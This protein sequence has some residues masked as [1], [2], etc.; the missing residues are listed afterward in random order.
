VSHCDTIFHAYKVEKASQGHTSVNTEHV[1]RGLQRCVAV[2][3]LGSYLNPGCFL[4]M[5]QAAGWENV[6]PNS[7]HLHMSRAI[8]LVKISRRRVTCLVG[9]SKA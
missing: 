1:A 4:R 3:G 8:R 7:V 5:H 6:F 9:S 2:C